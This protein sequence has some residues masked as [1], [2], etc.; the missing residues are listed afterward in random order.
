MHDATQALDRAIGL[1]DD[2]PVRAFLLERR[3]L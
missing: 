3:K 2:D 1:T